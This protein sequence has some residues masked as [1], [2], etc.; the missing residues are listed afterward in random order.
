MFAMLAAV[1]DGRVQPR[2]LPVERAHIHWVDNE[3]SKTFMMTLCWATL[4][5]LLINQ[6]TRWVVPRTDIW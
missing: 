1:N 3:A 5:A 6:V 4:P 2:P